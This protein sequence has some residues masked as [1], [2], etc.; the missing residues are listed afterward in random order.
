MDEVA[1]MSRTGLVFGVA[2]VV[3]LGAEAEHAAAQWQQTDVGWCEENRGGRD[4][5]RYCVALE[6]AFDAPSSLAVD[7]GTN[8]GVTVEGW[9]GDVVEVRAKVWAN[10]RSLERAEEIADEV[11]PRMVRGRLTAD[12]P[13]TGRRESWGVSW[14]VRVPYD[15]DLDIETFNGGIAVSD[16]TGRIRFE[17]L[18]GG[19]H[20][21]EV[22]GDVVGRTTNGGLHIELVG[23]TWEGEGID[24]ETTNGGVTLRVPEDYSARLETGTVNGGIDIDFPVTV[25]GRVGRRLTTT[26]GEGGP[27]IRAFTTNGGVHITRSGRTIR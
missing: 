16:V 4:Q 2:A 3:V 24:V 8:G 18:N 10:A 12:G 13:D 27:T 14:E 26:L 6:A 25:Q 21:T 17:A 7:G 11:E 22:G 23:S 1:K 20:L 5:D 9:G 15:T 19:V